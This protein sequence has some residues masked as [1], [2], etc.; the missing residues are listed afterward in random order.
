MPFL[1]KRVRMRSEGRSRN[2]SWDGRLHPWKVRARDLWLLGKILDGGADAMHGE[3]LSYVFFAGEFADELIQLG[4]A[5]AQRWIDEHPTDRW[6]LDPLPAWNPTAND[7]TCALSPRH[8]SRVRAITAAKEL[9]TVPRNG[10]NGA[11]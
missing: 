9:T 6:Q 5:D 7:G 10:S 4:Q 8:R 1:D 11:G 3:L 2:A